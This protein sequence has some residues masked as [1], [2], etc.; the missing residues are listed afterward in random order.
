MF[1]ILPKFFL[2]LRY[3]NFCPDFFSYAGERLDKKV[4]INFKFYGVIYWETSNAI[5]NCPMSQ[6]EI[7]G[8]FFSNVAEK[9]VRDLFLKN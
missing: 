8:L 7:L 5:P 6:K 4:Q 3:L 9:Q 2:F 1:Y